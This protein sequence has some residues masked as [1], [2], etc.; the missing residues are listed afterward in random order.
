MR[1]DLDT[2]TQIAKRMAASWGMGRVPRF[3]ADRQRVDQS[4]HAPIEITADIDRILLDEWEKTKAFLSE[5]QETLRVLTSDLLA[6]RRI[7]LRAE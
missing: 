1:D 7:V 5:K 2:A 4:Y 6:E 3:Y